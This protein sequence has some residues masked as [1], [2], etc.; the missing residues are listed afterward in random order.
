M[1]ELRDSL[2]KQ[3]LSREIEL[4]KKLEAEGKQEAASQHY[5]KAASISRMLGYK[6]TATQ[7]ETVGQVVKE[8]A[9]DQ[10]QIESSIDNLIVT[11]KPDTNWE[12]IGNLEEAK[13]TIKEAI[14]L[15][16]IKEKPSF[17]KSTR[18]ILLYGPPGTGKTM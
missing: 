13:T 16:F 5:L 11:Q 9:E 3:E 8:S 4:A 7:Y 14:V 1:G 2:L 12:D 10:T 17:V 15:P 18:T 6:E